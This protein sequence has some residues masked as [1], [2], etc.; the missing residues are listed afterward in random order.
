MQARRGFLNRRAGPFVGGP[1]PELKYVDQAVTDWAADSTG[2]I[3]YYSLTAQGD[4]VQS[5]QGRVV[6]WKSI[7]LTGMLK[8]QTTETLPNYARLL[9]VW[10]KQ[11]NS[12]AGALEQDILVNASSSITFK[13]LDNRERFVI[14][15]DIKIG[16]GERSV[17]PSSSLSD[18]NNTM[19]ID[20][21]IDLKGL[22]TVYSGTT[23]AIGSV[24]SGNIVILT[25]GSQA[26]GKGGIFSLAVRQRFYDN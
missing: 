1:K 12:S 15:R 13:N 11:N 23:A 26:V 8:P 20:E 18:G 25:T 14:L 5:R 24:A 10:D 19:C 3:G 2:T 16:Q 7:Q 17:V 21:F 22:K 9:V 4:D 6:T